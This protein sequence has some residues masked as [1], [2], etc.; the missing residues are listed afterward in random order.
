MITPVA[1]ML[2]PLNTFLLFCLW[3]VLAAE[4]HAAGLQQPTGI[5]QRPRPM[6]MEEDHSSA[7]SSKSTPH[8][9]AAA[10]NYSPLRDRCPYPQ[11]HL[12]LD[13]T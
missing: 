7:K 10:P 6:A 9:P 8:L 12:R 1:N 5:G 13:V 2:A 3:Q 4:E 11:T